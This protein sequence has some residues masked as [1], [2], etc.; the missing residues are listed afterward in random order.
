MLLQLGRY[1]INCPYLGVWR[2]E[3]PVVWD[4][5]PLRL[6]WKPE[7]CRGCKQ[8]ISFMELPEARLKADGV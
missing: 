5:K 7:D 4:D 8:C 6:D 1:I 2:C 3:A